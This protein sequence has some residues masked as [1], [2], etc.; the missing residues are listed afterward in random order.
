MSACCHKCGFRNPEGTKFCQ[1]SDPPCGELQRG[2]GP[3]KVV[4]SPR[5]TETEPCPSCGFANPTGTKFCENNNPPCGQL[6]AS[7]ARGKVAPS[8]K[9]QKEKAAGGK[10]DFF[11][12][13][14]KAAAPKE[15]KVKKTW[16]A[17]GT[18]GDMYGTGKYKGKKQVDF[19]APPPPQKSI[20]DLP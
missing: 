6:L 19:G 12:Q 9:F 13:Q 11:E 16:A 3:S 14:I 15:V 4:V 8:S 18:G 7:S 10:K 20:K 17:S 1:N 5:I 2:G